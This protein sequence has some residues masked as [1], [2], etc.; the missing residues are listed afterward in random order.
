MVCKG[1][2][3]SMILVLKWFFLWSS[4]ISNNSFLYFANLR[5]V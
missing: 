5:E 3:Q 1:A 4:G 2:P